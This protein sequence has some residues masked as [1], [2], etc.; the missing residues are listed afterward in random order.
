MVGGKIA[1]R[2]LW[3]TKWGPICQ[4]FEISIP[5][6]TSGQTPPTPGG[7]TPVC[8]LGIFYIGVVVMCDCV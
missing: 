6:F 3:P 4:H 2:F 7:D 8:V 5:F 1:H